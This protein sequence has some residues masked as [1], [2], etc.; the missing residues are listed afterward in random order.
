MLQ[1]FLLIPLD[2]LL[3]TLLLAEH[4]AAV[5]LHVEAQLPGLLLSRPEAGTEVTVQEPHA[6]APGHLLRD[7]RHALMLLVG[8]DKQRR[9]EAVKAVFRGKPGSL[10]QP[11]R[12][13]MAAAVVDILRHSA[14]E[15]PQAVVLLHDQLHTD[16]GRVGHQ[17]VPPGLVLLIRVDIGVEPVGHRLDPLAAQLVDTGHGAGGAAGMHQRFFHSFSFSAAHLSPC[18]P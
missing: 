12:V 1:R 3:I 11:H 8:A 7:P 5:F 14:A 6:V 9:G 17:R 10:L 4:A 16:G 15:L 13:A 18:C 2:L